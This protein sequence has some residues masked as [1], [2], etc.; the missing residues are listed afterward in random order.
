MSVTVG[1]RIT[2]IG[3]E[4]KLYIRCDGDT[5]LYGLFIC[6]AP[7]R[8]FEKLLVGKNPFFAVEASMRICGI[9]H[10]SHGIACCEA[11]EHAIGIYPPRDGLLLREACGILNRIQSHILHQFLILNDFFKKEFKKILLK[12]LFKALEF[13]NRLLSRI[14]G[15][16]TH[17]P[18]ITIGGLMKG[19]PEA[20]MGDIQ[21]DLGELEKLVREYVREF[22]LDDD[23]LSN[24]VDILREYNLELGKVASHMFYGDRF[25]INV[26]EVSVVHPMDLIENPI[27]EEL[28][29]ILA[30]SS[31]LC[32]LY[33]GKKVEVGPRS[34]MTIYR[35]FKGSTLYDLQR[36]RVLEMELNIERLKEIFNEVD[37]SAPVRTGEIPLRKGSGI[38]VFEAPRGTLI[39]KV[40]LDDTGHI[41]SY[42]VIVPTMFNI[43]VIGEAVRGIPKSMASVIPRL[44]DPCIPCA[45]HMVEVRT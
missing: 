6:E 13:C 37:L 39:H 12:N 38:G 32:A 5:V 20:R 25:N 14:G 36:A 33:R 44:F 43:P 9:C 22:F 45:V 2:R 34:R 24:K 28:R 11:I 41:E 7:V 30:K 18:N 10:T 31:A 1:E 19:V 4:A 16:P 40:K 29:G 21:R 23:K 26:E 17:P 8:G 15:A 42:K 35:G 3:G 27:S